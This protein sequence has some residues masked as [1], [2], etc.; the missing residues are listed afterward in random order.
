VLARDVILSVY[1]RFE[2]GFDTLDLREPRDLLDLFAD[3]DQ[4]Y[5]AYAPVSV[6]TLP[7][8]ETTGSS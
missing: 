1:E 5:S 7:L 8:V 3:A 2:E 6:Q 4:R